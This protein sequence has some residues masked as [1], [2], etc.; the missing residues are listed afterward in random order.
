MLR[1]EEILPNDH[2]QGIVPYEAVKI[3]EILAKN[4]SSLC[5]SY[6]VP[7]CIGLSTSRL[8]RD[9]ESK[10]TRCEV[11]P[12]CERISRLDIP[13]E[14]GEPNSWQCKSCGV[15]GV[16]SMFNNISPA[17][18]SHG[19]QSLHANEILTRIESMTSPAGN[20]NP[21]ICGG[22]LEERHILG[23][24]LLARH[25][26][27]G[28]KA[29]IINFDES[30]FNSLTKFTN[31]FS[32][33]I[34]DYNSEYW[35]YPIISTDLHKQQ[36]SLVNSKYKSINND[37]E[38]AYKQ[39]AKQLLINT[40]KEIKDIRTFLSANQ[41]ILLYINGIDKIAD[42]NE[43]KYTMEVDEAFFST[44]YC[45]YECNNNNKMKFIITAGNYE[46]FCADRISKQVQLYV[47]PSIFFKTN[48]VSAYEINRNLIY[49]DVDMYLLANNLNK[50][51]FLYSKEHKDIFH[52]KLIVH[53]DLE[54]LI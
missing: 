48:L 4:D 20:W 35:N 47:T 25:L 40:I 24:Q 51:S 53:P 7:G 41:S 16:G 32:G 52:A 43:D 9:Y 39:W 3:L 34:F 45:D 27:N 13:T 50:Y 12:V 1:L 11:C 31:I 49:F 36:L 26:L 23:S 6:A 44:L 33:R 15:F 18:G 42:N 5:V 28:G 19:V 14:A 46:I 2:I 30:S 17:L 22:T 29:V 10:L 38:R 21:L 54:K 37:G 8:N